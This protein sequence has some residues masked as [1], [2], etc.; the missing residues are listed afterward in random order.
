MDLWHP[1]PLCLLS[2]GTNN[3]YTFLWGIYD[4]QILVLYILSFLNSYY[5]FLWLNR[6]S[7]KC[8]LLQLILFF[9][10][11]NKREIGAISESELIFAKL[12]KGKSMPYL[13][14][15][16]KCRCC[17]EHFMGYEKLKYKVGWNIYGS[18][19]HILT[20]FQQI[21]YPFSQV[22]FVRMCQKST[23]FGLILTPW[24][25]KSRVTSYM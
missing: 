11:W 24:C 12:S 21:W 18:Y 9:F 3:K 19:S 10:R 20:D 23:P 6:Y 5:E 4:I 17:G 14:F 22:E 13:I 15:G 25:P 2:R 8:I 16:L 1:T 7:P